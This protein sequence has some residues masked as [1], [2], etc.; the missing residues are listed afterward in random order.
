MGFVLVPRHVSADRDRRICGGWVSNGPCEEPAVNER[1]ARQSF[2]GPKSD[3][4]F[5]NCR[6]SIIGL[7]GGGS[8]V[9]QQLAHIGIGSFL[10]FDSDHVEDSNLNR[11]VA[12]T[13]ADIAS[14]TP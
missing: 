6:V 1:Y 7:G 12:A 3:E 2:L 11:L 13:Q 5:K 10:L 8:H 4:T 9:V 14:K